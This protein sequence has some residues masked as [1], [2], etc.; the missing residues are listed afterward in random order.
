MSYLPT[1]GVLLLIAGAVSAF[2]GLQ[3]VGVSDLDSADAVYLLLGGGVTAALVGLVLLVVGI[4]SGR[5]G[6]R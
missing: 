4:R 6:A 1:I 3:G 5:S 2:V